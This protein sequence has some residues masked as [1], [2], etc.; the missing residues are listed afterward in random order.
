MLGNC[1]NALRDFPNK[2]SDQYYID[3]AQIYLDQHKFDEAIDK[4]MPVLQTQPQ[5]QLVVK[6]AVLSHAGRAGLRVL[7]MVL[8]LANMSGSTFFKTFAEH[9]PNADESTISDINTAV[10][11]LETF[12]NDP[13]AR[14]SE[15]NLISMFLYFSVIGVHLNAYA[16]EADNVLDSSFNSCSTVDLPD[17][18]NS[19]I[20]QSTAKALEASEHIS[21]SGDISDAMSDLFENPLLT[22]FANAQETECPGV[23]N[24]EN[25]ACEGMRSMINEGSANVGLGSGAATPCL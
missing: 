1:S 16:Y 20:V 4:I 21:D 9:F 17:E 5:N 13:A 19:V 24:D 10:N 15:L 22:P 11:I 14:D 8:S 3:Q 6:I 18:Q 2:S 23:N 12:E 25:L 7:D